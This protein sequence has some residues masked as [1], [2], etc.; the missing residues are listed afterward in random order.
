MKKHINGIVV[1]EGK[2]DVAFLSNY[3]DAEF[4]ITSFVVSDGDTSRGKRETLLNSNP[5]FFSKSSKSLPLIL[6]TL[7]PNAF[8]LESKGSGPITS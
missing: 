7:K 1:V 4:V 5:V 8:A 6:T 3:I 2:S